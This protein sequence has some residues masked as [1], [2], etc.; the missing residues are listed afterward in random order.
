M[1]RTT[2]SRPDVPEDETS[3]GMRCPRPAAGRGAGR[4]DAEGGRGRF[5]SSGTECGGGAG[6]GVEAYI[7]SGICAWAIPRSTLRCCSACRALQLRRAALQLRSHKPHRALGAHSPG[8]RTERRQRE[9]CARHSPAVTVDQGHGGSRSGPGRSWTQRLS[10][11]AA[12][13]SPARLG[14]RPALRTWHANC[15]NGMNPNNR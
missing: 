6:S 12:P 3:N 4:P 1:R 11:A 13:L 9:Q 5:T 14:G 10:A 15:T 2:P 8:R 7:V